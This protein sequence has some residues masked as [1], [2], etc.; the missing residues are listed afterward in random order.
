MTDRA[1][2]TSDERSVYVVA[3]EPIEMMFSQSVLLV[4]QIVGSK[5]FSCF[6]FK[7]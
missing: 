7:T 6:V 3:D 2:S 1:A 4:I 5:I